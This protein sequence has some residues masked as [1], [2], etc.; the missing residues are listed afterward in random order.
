MENNKLTNEEIKGILVEFYR[1]ARDGDYLSALEKHTSKLADASKP[2]V[3]PQI[4]TEDK[5]ISVEDRLPERGNTVLTF[6]DFGD[7]THT[8][9]GC[10]DKHYKLNNITHWMNLPKAP[11]SK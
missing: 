7:A 1:E 10:I 3:E 6:Q 11:L 9:T 8:D 4:N 2:T 5:W